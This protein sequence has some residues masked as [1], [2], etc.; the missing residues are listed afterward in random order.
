MSFKGAEKTY[1]HYAFKW[2]IIALVFSHTWS[3]L[4]RLRLS[5][6]SSVWN[7][8]RRFISSWHDRWQQSSCR[9]SLCPSAPY[10]LLMSLAMSSWVFQ[11]SSSGLH[12]MAK[13]A[14]YPR[15]WES[16]D[17]SDETF[18]SRCCYDM[19]CNAVCPEHVTTSLF[20]MWSRHEIPRVLLRQWR[21]NTLIILVAFAVVFHVSPA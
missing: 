7:I 16:Q 12:S 13:V 11:C 14:S 5:S 3:I 6:S 15:W 4:L 1:C 18:S 8:G 19:S 2:W 10:I 21:W 17:V 9:S 20:V